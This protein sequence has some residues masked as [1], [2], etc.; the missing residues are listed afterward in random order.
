MMMYDWHRL[1]TQLTM[2]KMMQKAAKVTIDPSV[3]DGGMAEIYQSQNTKQALLRKVDDHNFVRITNFVKCRDFLVDT[4]SFAK[5]N[6]DFGIYGFSFQ[7]SKMQ[8]DWTGAYIMLHFSDAKS[9][10]N[11]LEQVE[12]IQAIEE[13]NKFTPTKVL[14]VEGSQDLIAVGDKKWLGNCLMFSFYSLLLRIACY[15][16]NTEKDWIAD[17]S[18]KQHSDSKYIA[19]VPRKSMDKI[20]ADLSLLE[21]PTFCGFDPKKDSVGSIHHNSGFISVFGWHTEISPET[22]KKNK[23]WK[24]MQERGLETN[25]A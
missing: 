19:A 9:R 7:G 24:L 13:K 21:T 11:F 3:K 8:P 5:E 2:E 14:K 18:S 12:I 10:Q 4:Y 22:V 15:D 6:K 16:L 23:H 1:T 20:L 25:V 17:F